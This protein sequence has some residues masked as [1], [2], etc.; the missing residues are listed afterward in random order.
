MS[1]AATLATW[2]VDFDASLTGI[3]I[4]LYFLPCSATTTR[5]ALRLVFPFSLESDSS[6]QNSV[7]FLAVVVALGALASIGV[8]G[9]GVSLRGDS[10]TA[11]SWS[12]S[13]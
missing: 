12:S 2:H 13:L 8:S 7:E 6:F 4:L 5:F 11:L 10:T 1:F 9:C 3:G